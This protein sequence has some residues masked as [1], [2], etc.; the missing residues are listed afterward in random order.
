MGVASL[1]MEKVKVATL[2][3][4]GVLDGLPVERVMEAGLNGLLLIGDMGQ[5]NSG[6]NPPQALGELLLTP[7]I[8][9][10]EPE[11]SN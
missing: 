7:S 8:L 10:L 2:P 6:K 4:E 11:L 3:V 9:T 5:K 1:P